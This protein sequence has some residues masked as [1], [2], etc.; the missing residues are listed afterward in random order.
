[1]NPNS[2]HRWCRRNKK[3][4]LTAKSNNFVLAEKYQNMRKT[5]Y[6]KRRWEIWKSITY[7]EVAHVFH[8]FFTENEEA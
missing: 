7:N 5:L 8:D 2:S 6:G 4:E 3:N 1:M